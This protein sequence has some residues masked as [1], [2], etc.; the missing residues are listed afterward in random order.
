MEP[1]EYAISKD[2]RNTQIVRELDR[3]RQRELFQYAGVGMVIVA[4]LLYSAWQHFELVRHG[5]R[6]EEMQK[7]T[8][9]EEAINRSL[10]LQL[11]VLKSPQR[12]ERLATQRLRMIEAGPQTAI[13]LE[14]ATPVDP[15]A[16]SIL[17][18]R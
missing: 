7:Q 1:L 12:I 2:I 5:Y 17:A 14:R 9:D 18:R 11:Q 16:K 4:L 8:K 10:K 6:V 15:P 13:V 3:T